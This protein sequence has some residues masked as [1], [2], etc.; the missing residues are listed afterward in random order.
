MPFEAV[1][2]PLPLLDS[3][4]PVELSFE[5]TVIVHFPFEESDN[6]QELL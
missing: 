4:S 6:D 2:V 3:Y 5:Y 1:Y